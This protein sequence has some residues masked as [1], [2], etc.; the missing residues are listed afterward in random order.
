V[1]R[2][3]LATEGT[4]L[5]RAFLFV[6]AA[7]SPLVACQMLVGI[8]DD[9]FSVARPAPT[10]DA[11]TDAD[12][13]LPDLCAHRGPPARPEGG[14]EGEARR[15]V[16]AVDKYVLDDKTAGFDL[17][18][19]CT[20]DPLDRSR[21]AGQPTCTSSTSGP[22]CDGDGGV[23]NSLAAALEP[24]DGLL[25][26]N[27]VFNRNVACGRATVLIV[28][29]DYNGE[30]DDLDVKLSVIEGL[31]ILDESD[32]GAGADAGCAA[33]GGPPTLPPRR[34][35]TDPWTVPPGATTPG[36]RTEVSGWVKNFQV[37]VD[38]RQSTSTLPFLFGRT[39]LTLSG[40]VLTGDLVPLGKTGED[41]PVVDGRIQGGPATSFR[42]TRATLG[43]RAPARQVVVAAGQLETGLPPLCNA[44]EWPFLKSVI[45]STA[46]SLQNIGLDR[47]GLPCDAISVGVR[48]EAVPALI[49]KENSRTEPSPCGPDWSKQTC[50]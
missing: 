17:D 18:H 43:G 36:A 30:A 48:L 45:C 46:D 23:D 44:P 42:L 49:G 21:G 24:V 41:L 3:A 28:L 31:G 9:R 39:L 6:L 37:A 7:A 33:S 27:E 19:A 38:G 12:T 22:T 50:P 1:K 10:P 14:A 4:P 47:M 8:D 25:D 11:S 20:C 5:R 35:G 32:G 34:D 15:F 40:V 26:I 13:P 16:L 29:S 2:L